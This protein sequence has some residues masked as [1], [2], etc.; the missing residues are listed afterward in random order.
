MH[1]SNS[2]E[3]I[4]L[5]LFGMP[6]PGLEDTSP[7]LVAVT[8]QNI[9]L[10]SRT[11]FCPGRKH[12]SSSIDSEL[13]NSSKALSELGTHSLIPGAEEHWP[14]LS[15]FLLAAQQHPFLQKTNKQ[16][17]SEGLPIT[18]RASVRRGY[19]SSTFPLLSTYAKGTSAVDNTLSFS[20]LSG[21]CCLS[22]R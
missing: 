22:I 10:L 15:F 20:L 17:H 11:T 2:S 9:L 18:L 4:L 14:L 5:F 3:V 13:P 19:E 1:Q 21:S 16:K 8:F 7:C 6:I 12:L